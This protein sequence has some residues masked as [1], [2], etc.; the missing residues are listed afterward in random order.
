MYNSVL[1]LIRGLELV[2]SGGG[3]RTRWPW[4]QSLAFRVPQ[5]GGVMFGKW[6]RMGHEGIFISTLREV[7]LRQGA[8]SRGSK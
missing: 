6:V 5:A 3:G 8:P 7:R 1:P 2:T 4:V